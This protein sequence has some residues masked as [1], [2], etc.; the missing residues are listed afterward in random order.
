MNTQEV[1]LLDLRE[2]YEQSPSVTTAIGI[3]T[4]Y[5]SSKLERL[6]RFH[7]D[8][9]VHGD[10][11]TRRASVD[12]LLEY[13][14]LMEVACIAGY[15]PRRLPADYAAIA[16]SRLAN[17]SVRR[18]YQEYYPLLLP[19]LH[20]QRLRGRWTRT[21]AGAATGSLFVAFTSLSR[22]TTDP[23]V[24]TFL[25]LLEDG[26]VGTTSLEDLLAVLAD[27]VKFAEVLF[28]GSPEV[29][30]A[31]EDVW[32]VIS[33][34][35]ALSN[36]TEL[37]ARLQPPIVELDKA[38]QSL[39]GFRKFLLFCRDLNRL[40]ETASDR[41]L[42]QSAMWHYHAYWFGEMGRKL[43]PYL[44]SAID[45]FVTW[46][47]D[48]TDADM[49][50]RRSHAATEMRSAVIA[51]TSRKYAV[52]LRRAAAGLANRRERSDKGSQSTISSASRLAGFS[53]ARTSGKALSKAQIADHLAKSTGQNKRVAARFLDD[54]TAL[55]YR[56]AKN[57]FTIPGVGKLVLVNRKARMGRNPAT[58]EEIKVPAKRLVKFRVSK[59]AKDVILRT[60]K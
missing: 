60:K 21:E 4:H 24:D 8:D 11:T 34:A 37:L 29:M 15:V 47:V 14:S 19:Q 9:P 39:H 13:Y 7:G 3:V 23:H 1:N 45:R 53:L 30:Q 56:E 31:D 48:A 35:A 51:L 12:E 41:P 2:R 28:K 18:Y 32:R 26:S 55:A 50:L 10:E 43:R 42:I 5:P 27:P 22:V 25:W 16:I 59:K 17:P 40:L 58:G 36:P 6:L 44:E 52:K 57:S 49:T 54:L 20:V 38:E 46:Q 33:D